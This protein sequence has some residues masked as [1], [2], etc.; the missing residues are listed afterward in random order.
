M[1]L[2]DYFQTSFESAPVLMVPATGEVGDTGLG[3]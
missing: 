2:E 3:H 1:E